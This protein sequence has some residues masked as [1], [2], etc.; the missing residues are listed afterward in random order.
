MKFVQFSDNTK[1]K[2]I[3][4][5]GCEQ[6]QEEYP[7]QELIDDNDQRYIDFVN[8]NSGNGVEAN[9]KRSALLASSDWTVGNDSPLSTAKQDDWKVYRQALR[10]ITSQSGYPD[11]IVWPVAPV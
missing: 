1:S 3:S 2:I 6:D 7:N 11:S 8:A 5:F 9:R 4:V 10:D